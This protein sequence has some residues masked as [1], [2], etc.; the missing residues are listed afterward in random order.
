MSI[1]FSY[2]RTLYSPLLKDWAE[3]MVRLLPQ[4]VSV[5]VSTSS[6]GCALAS[7]MIV[8]AAQQGRRLEN[9]YVRKNNESAHA[10]RSC[11]LLWLD[12]CENRVAAF[13]DDFINSGETFKRAVREIGGVV[14]LQYIATVTGPI[15]ANKSDGLEM[16]SEIAGK[17]IYWIVAYNEQ[18]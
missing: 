6:S 17:P 16:L 1:G 3:L 8:I 13:V 9:I 12:T 5:L 10:G 18:Q 7:A 15:D 4:R 11:D 14:E 2:N